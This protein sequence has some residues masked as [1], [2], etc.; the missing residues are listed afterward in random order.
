VRPVLFALAALVLGS[1]AA[2]SVPAM[3]ITRF[4]TVTEN[5]YPAF[6]R[7][8]DDSA[9]ARRVYDGVR[10]LP[11]APKDRFCP[12]GF[13]LRYRLSFNELAR[14]NLSVVIEGDACAEVIFSDIDRR[15]TDDV[16]WDLL[17]D[18]SGVKKAEIYRLLPDGLRR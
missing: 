8:V 6:D 2:T 4:S 14:V 5:H 1:C 18:A 9:T 12:A 16:F 3:R 10:A 15:A 13:G 7:S 17:A 11:P